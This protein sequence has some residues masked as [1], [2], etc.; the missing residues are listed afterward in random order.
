MKS[1][2]LLFVVIGLGLAVNAPGGNMPEI[3]EDD[4]GEPEGIKL[5]FPQELIDN[6]RDKYW[7][8]Q[9]EES[10]REV[11]N[12]L[13]SQESFNAW[14]REQTKINNTDPV[15]LRDTLRKYARILLV[16]NE[17][18]YALDG[19]FCKKVGLGSVLETI[20]LK[21]A[22]PCSCCYYTEEEAYI[23]ELKLILLDCF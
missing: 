4:E 22:K 1:K 6:C 8:L 2:N 13:S 12:I 10:E 7:A 21:G 20:H 5:N 19:D 18:V 23:K 15:K 11:E 3:I 14:S 9:S 17:N 16:A